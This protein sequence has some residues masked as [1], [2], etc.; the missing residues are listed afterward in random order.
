V[1]GSHVIGVLARSVQINIQSIGMV[2]NNNASV[3]WCN[4]KL[5][6]SIYNNTESEWDL[7]KIYHSLCDEWSRYIQIN[8]QWGKG[9]ADH[10]VREI[11]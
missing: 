11:M 4:Q 2:C 6:A 8:L 5:I 7:L 1:K 10:E 9:H 3:K